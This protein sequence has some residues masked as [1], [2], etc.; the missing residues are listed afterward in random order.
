[1]RVN[2]SSA[3]FGAPSELPYATSLI[4]DAELTAALSFH[5][6]TYLTY[7]CFRHA[8]AIDLRISQVGLRAWIA[9][10]Q[11]FHNRA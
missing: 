8:S 9:F 11:R 2:S 6:I 5:P 10:K 3:T 7:V 1:M 4:T